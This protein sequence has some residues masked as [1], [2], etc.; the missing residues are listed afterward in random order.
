MKTF[1][2]VDLNR[3][4]KDVLKAAREEAVLIS[5]RSQGDFVVIPVE[6]Y[7]SLIIN[8]GK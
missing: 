5:N 1:N 4:G 3:K 7:E 2:M 6:V 8:K